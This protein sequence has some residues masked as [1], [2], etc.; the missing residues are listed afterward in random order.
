MK[1]RQARI[2]QFLEGMGGENRTVPL[3]VREF[4]FSVCRMA[5]S[6]GIPLVE[7]DDDSVGGLRHLLQTGGQALAGR[8]VM[9][10]FIPLV[11]S[12]EIERLQEELRVTVPPSKAGGEIQRAQYRDCTLIFDG[13]TSVA[14]LYCVVCRF[15]TDDGYIQQRVIGLEH[16]VCALSSPQLCSA[17]S[18]V[19]FGPPFNL[20]AARILGLMHDR[21]SVNI[22]AMTMLRPICLN[23]EFIGCLSHTLSN[24]G[25]KMEN[26]LTEA[27]YLFVSP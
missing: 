16:L 21:A 15:V 1:Q 2:S 23:A 22:L 24:A 5:L 17:L 13:A 27:T 8:A 11:F 14:D 19:L 20:E 10:A 12:E 26:S 18:Q 7:F 25:K 4:R 6:R 3:A 9:S